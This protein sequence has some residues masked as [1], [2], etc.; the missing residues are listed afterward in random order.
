[1]EEYTSFPC[2]SYC[3]VQVGKLKRVKYVIFVT[4]T[5]MNGGKDFSNPALPIQVHPNCKTIYKGVNPNVDSYSAFYDNRKLSKTQLEEIIRKEG[6]TDLYICGIATDVCVG[7]SAL[8]GH[9]Q[10]SKDTW[11]YL[12][13]RNL[14]RCVHLSSL[15][16]KV[17]IAIIIVWFCICSE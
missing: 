14:F 12:S 3:G 13:I 1:M 15:N 6:C 8:T 7:M 2:W 5:H 9:F 17:Y 4:V 10:Q 11:K 16:T